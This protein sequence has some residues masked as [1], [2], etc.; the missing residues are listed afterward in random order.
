MSKWVRVE[1]RKYPH[2][3]HLSWEA[4]EL[5]VGEHGTW[6]FA[7]KVVRNN[8]PASGVQLLPASRWWVA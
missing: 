1:K 5:E 4:I 8:H 2:Q 6:V 7:L 3:T